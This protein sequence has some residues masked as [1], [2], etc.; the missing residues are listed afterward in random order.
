[1][2]LVCLF[3][4]IYFVFV[5]SNK[6]AL[7]DPFYLSLVIFAAPHFLRC[8]KRAILAPFPYT[9]RQFSSLMAHEHVNAAHA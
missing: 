4:V 2:G 8:L 5:D 6:V 1:M 7:L 3:L 9:L